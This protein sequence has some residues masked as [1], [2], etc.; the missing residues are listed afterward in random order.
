[1]IFIILRVDLKPDLA[2]QMGHILSFIYDRC[3]N[4]TNAADWIDLINVI[5][6]IDW[7]IIS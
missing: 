3:S 6:I 1:M 7:N 5:D 2:S 4:S